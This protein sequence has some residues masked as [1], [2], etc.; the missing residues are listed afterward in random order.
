M[1][2]VSARGV[3][4]LCLVEYG[5]PAGEEVECVLGWGIG[6]GGVGEECQSGVGREFHG[7]EGQVE[8]ADDGG[9]Q[10]IRSVHLTAEHRDLVAQYQ[11]LDLRGAVTA[12]RQK[13][14]LEKCIAARCRSTTRTRL[15]IMPAPGH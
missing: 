2:S 10:K 11:D 13:Q 6:F 3:G 1:W 7:L 12:Q 4:P 9:R 15:V 14:E 5:G 8:V